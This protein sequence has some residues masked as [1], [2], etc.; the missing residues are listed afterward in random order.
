M[1]HR[2]AVFPGYDSTA[3]IF[4]AK[5]CALLNKCKALQETQA[6]LQCQS[7]N[8]GHAQVRRT[9][10]YAHF[11]FAFR[12]QR[13]SILVRAVDER[14]LVWDRLIFR[15]IRWLSFDL[16]FFFFLFSSLHLHTHSL[17][18]HLTRTCY[19]RSLFDLVHKSS[20]GTFSSSFSL[21]SLSS[22]FAARR[23]QLI[24]A[25]VT[26]HFSYFYHGSSK[27]YLES[28]QDAASPQFGCSR[29]PDDLLLNRRPCRYSP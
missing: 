15:S 20:S 14:S 4:S 23:S 28:K 6:R 1:G 22:C 7:S 17:A 9:A 2:L 13:P 16:P 11:F 12:R 19:S 18:L 21:S 26:L 24:I 27:E 29:S 25:R 10:P 8:G 3:S 5:I